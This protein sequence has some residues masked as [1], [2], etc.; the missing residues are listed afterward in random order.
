MQAT[1]E[2]V[3]EPP[4]SSKAVHSSLQPVL[5]HHFGHP[6]AAKD[7]PMSDSLA[8]TA[9]AARVLSGCMGCPP[10][11]LRKQVAKAGV[12][13]VKRMETRFLLEARLLRLPAGLNDCRVGETICKSRGRPHTLAERPPALPMSLKTHTSHSLSWEQP[14]LSSLGMERTSELQH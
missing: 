3:P 4:N 2:C 1:W 7:L 9:I 10:G 13:V 12:L 8:L 6:R 14:H 5:D 11:K